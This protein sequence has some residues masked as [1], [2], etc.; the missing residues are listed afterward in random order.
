M[1]ELEQDPGSAAEPVEKAT[2]WTQALTET[3]K[4]ASEPD[5]S[6]ETPAAASE[7]AQDSGTASGSPAPGALVAVDPLGSAFRVR[8]GIAGTDRSEGMGSVLPVRRRY[9]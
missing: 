4:A 2:D 8:T 6:T 9:S 5:P 3:L 1:S 7:P